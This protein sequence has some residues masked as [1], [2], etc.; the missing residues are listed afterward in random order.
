M[1]VCDDSILPPSSPEAMDY[2]AASMCSAAKRS[3]TD[4]NDTVAA[5]RLVE[6]INRS[7]LMTNSSLAKPAGE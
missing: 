1:S 7:S 2:V 5:L 6:D 4:H 3:P